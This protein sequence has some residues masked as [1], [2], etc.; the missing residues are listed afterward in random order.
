MI[1]NSIDK[2][3]KVD[4]P[5]IFSSSVETKPSVFEGNQVLFIIPSEEKFESLKDEEGIYEVDAD[6]G[7]LF[8]KQW[9]VYV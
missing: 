8:N 3:W 9:I 1:W 6:F 5:T 2:K 7:L 4:F